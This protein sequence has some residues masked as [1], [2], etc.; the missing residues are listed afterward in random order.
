MHFY[1]EKK[2]KEKKMIL[3]MQCMERRK[4]SRQKEGDA[5]NERDIDSRRGT[6]G[7]GK[8][9]GHTQRINLSFSGIHS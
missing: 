9:R 2:R 5:N 1:K 4:M 6:R 8:R 7:E 3:D